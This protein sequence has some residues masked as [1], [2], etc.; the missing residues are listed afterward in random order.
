M[1]LSILDKI[2]EN[3]KIYPEIKR[4]NSPHEYYVDGTVDYVD[5]KNQMI[6]KLRKESSNGK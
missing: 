6:L 1:D 5:S 2:V 3:A 4:L